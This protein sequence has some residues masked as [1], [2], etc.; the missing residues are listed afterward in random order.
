MY[1]VHFYMY[2]YTYNKYRYKY[3]KWF[4]LS[5]RNLT[6]PLLS[7]RFRHSK[8][9]TIMSHSYQNKSVELDFV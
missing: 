7:F 9:F 3:K 5:V 4:I 8:R 1:N 6:I 2:N